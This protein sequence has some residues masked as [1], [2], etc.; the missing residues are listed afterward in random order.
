MVVDWTDSM[1]RSSALLL[2]VASWWVT[3]LVV[4]LRK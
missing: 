3:I 4:V 1:G 2:A